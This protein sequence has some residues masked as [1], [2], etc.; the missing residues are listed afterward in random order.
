MVAVFQDV[1]LV[2]IVILTLRFDIAFTALDKNGVFMFS[3]AW[4]LN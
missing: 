2:A 1:R 4:F 3:N